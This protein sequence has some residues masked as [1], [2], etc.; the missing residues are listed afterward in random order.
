[1][2]KPPAAMPAVSG[3][4]PVSPMDA[5]HTSVVVAR[6]P[7]GLTSPSYQA[8]PWPFARIRGQTAMLYS[9]IGMSS[10]YLP[11]VIFTALIIAFGGVSLAAARLLRPSRPD[12]V[13]LANY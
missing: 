7:P 4:E 1:M 5:A 11:V 12:P 6:W 9:R 10:E 2:R 8:P 3:I 13:K